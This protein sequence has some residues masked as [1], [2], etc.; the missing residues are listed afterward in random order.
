[1]W[2]VGLCGVY[3]GNKNNDMVML[4]IGNQVSKV[5]YFIKGWR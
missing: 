5:A 2:F 3:D 1:M 4:V